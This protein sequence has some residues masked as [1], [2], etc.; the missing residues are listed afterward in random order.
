LVTGPGIRKPQFETCP[1]TAGIRNMLLYYITD[2]RQLVAGEELIE[3]IRAAFA[4]GVDWVQIREK[5]LPAREL[6]RLVERA[7]ALPERK[8]G[9]LLVNE[10]ADVA[11]GCG[12]DGVHLPAG[13]PPA[14]AFR[15][16]VPEGWLIGV[17]CHTVKEV[18]QAAEEGASFAVLGPLFATPGKGPPLGLAML[19]E[20]CAACASRSSCLPSGAP[21]AA[22]PGVPVL[23]LGG[24]NTTNA[25]A[26]LDAGAAGLAAIR[27]FQS[28][29]V[30]QTVR[31][32][33][34]LV[35]GSGGR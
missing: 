19:R 10:R 11:L 4:A 31:L 33:R 14:S 7:A 23:A 35:P 34:G 27:L 26:C 25:K 32:I 24:I 15:A 21:P 29:E 1:G 18:L 12:A 13:S 17:S 8:Q 2:S 9:R 22:G 30:F 16:H 6:W 28:G 3:K 20:A 5:H